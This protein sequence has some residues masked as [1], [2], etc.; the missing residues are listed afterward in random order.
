MGSYLNQLILDSRRVLAEWKK[1]KNRELAADLVSIWSAFQRA[2]PAVKESVDL[3]KE[4]LSNTKYVFDSAEEFLIYQAETWLF[5]VE[6]AVVELKKT[7]VQRENYICLLFR[8]LDDFELIT[9]AKET[10]GVEPSI[11]ARKLLVRC[12]RKLREHYEF[13]APAIEMIREI[14][15]SALPEPKLPAR[16]AATLRKCDFILERVS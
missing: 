14:R 1:V 5:H 12:K 4:I 8:E 9:W 6:G 7:G 16:L 2:I 13:F 10:H 15:Y 3:Y 11:D